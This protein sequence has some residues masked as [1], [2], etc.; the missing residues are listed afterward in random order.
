MAVE[1]EDPLDAT[2]ERLSETA[3][4]TEQPPGDPVER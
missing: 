4:E 1:G 3:P 2:G